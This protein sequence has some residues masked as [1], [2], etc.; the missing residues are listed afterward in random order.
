G[1]E[2]VVN[3]PTMSLGDYHLFEIKADKLPIGV[4]IDGVVDIY[5]NH[6]IPVDK[7][8]T[9]YLFT[10]GYADQ[11]GAPMEK[12]SKYHRLKDLL[13]PNQDKKMIE[14]KR[15]LVRTFSK[16]KGEEDQ[17]DDVLIMGLRI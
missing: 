11:F 14:Q 16:W 2:K 3:H 7:G 5:T 6:T 1:V 9:V 17:I 15:I 13:L 8:D 10:V 12:K 4:N